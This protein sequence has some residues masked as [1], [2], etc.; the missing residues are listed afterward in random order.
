MCSVLS[1][2]LLQMSTMGP[3]DKIFGS[4]TYYLLSQGVACYVLSEKII[5]GILKSYKTK[6]QE[7]FHKSEK[8][9]PNKYNKKY[10]DKNCSKIN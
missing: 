8:Q 10:F 7:K 2:G 9:K 1:L 4:F 6:Q 5:K 3:F